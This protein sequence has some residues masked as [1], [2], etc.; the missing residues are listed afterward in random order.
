MKLIDIAKKY[1]WYDD[2][3]DTIKAHIEFEAG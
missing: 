3:A 1:G 2:G